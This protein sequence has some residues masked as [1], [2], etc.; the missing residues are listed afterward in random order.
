MIV[1]WGNCKQIIKYQVLEQYEDSLNNID[2]VTPNSLALESK[3]YKIKYMLNFENTS[4]SDGIVFKDEVF[5]VANDFYNNDAN[6]II[7]HGVLKYYEA[8]DRIESL[9]VLKPR[10]NAINE[11][12][13]KIESDALYDGFVKETGRIR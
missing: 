2:F 5:F 4:L 13:R 1:F 12:Q 9:V 10:V 8:V 3:D 6:N 11:D 7:Y